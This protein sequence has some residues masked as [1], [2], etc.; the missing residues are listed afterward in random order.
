MHSSGLQAALRGREIAMTLQDALT[1]L[2]PALRIKQQLAEV[3]VQDDHST[4]AT[5]S[6]PIKDGA[7][8]IA[9]VK[10]GAGTQ[11]LSGSNSFTGPATVELLGLPHGATC[12]PLTFTQDQTELTF[13]IAVTRG[14]AVSNVSVGMMPS[15]M[16]AVA[17]T[18]ASLSPPWMTSELREE[19]S[20]P[21][22]RSI[23]R[24]T[25]ARPR[26]ARA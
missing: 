23:S 4:D 19:T 17:T 8:S 25:T 3:L 15:L 20:S 26:R 10:N 21:M 18:A 12:P 22:P 14:P 2:N 6:G 24:C 1:S 9:L 5:F 11:T 7:G 16:A 13:P